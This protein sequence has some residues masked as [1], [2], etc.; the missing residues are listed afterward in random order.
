MPL[1]LMTSF[2]IN[3]FQIVFLND[4]TSKWLS[5]KAGVPQGSTLKPL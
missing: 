1:K 3:R 4:Q 5:V 2:P